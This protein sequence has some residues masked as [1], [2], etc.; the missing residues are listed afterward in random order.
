MKI[1]DVRFTIEDINSLSSNKIWKNWPVVYILHN[2]KEAYI[3]ETTS[4][5]HR[6]KQHREN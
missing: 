2:D 5:Y 6:M 3:G 4:A 1:N